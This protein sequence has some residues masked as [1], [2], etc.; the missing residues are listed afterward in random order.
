MVI[1]LLSLLLGCSD[2]EE[3]SKLCD[4]AVFFAD[5]DDDGF[6]SPYVQQEACETP[7]GYVDNNEDCDDTDADQF[8]TLSGSLTLLATGMVTLQPV[9]RMY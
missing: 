1:G 9:D 8:P 6:G 5:A 2:S 3:E 7:S 4:K